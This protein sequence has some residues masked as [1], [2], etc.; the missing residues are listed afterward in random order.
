MV[1][2]FITGVVIV[3]IAGMFLESIPLFLLGVALMMTPAIIEIIG[4]QKQVNKLN[5]RRKG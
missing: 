4:I 5:K 1:A 2:L 3:F